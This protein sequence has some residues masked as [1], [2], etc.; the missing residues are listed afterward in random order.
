[1]PTNS[2][3]SSQLPDW[4]KHIADTSNI[5]AYVLSV[6]VILGNSV[7]VAAILKYKNLQTKTNALVCSL[8]FSDITV[9]LNTIISR[10]CACH[11]NAVHMLVISIFLY[12]SYHTSVSH[13]FIIALERYVAI[14]YPFAYIKYVSKRLIATSIIIVWIIPLILWSICWSVQE[15]IGPKGWVKK[16]GPW[17]YLIQGVIFV[18]MYI[19]ILVVSYQQAS[20]IRHLSRQNTNKNKFKSE[21]KATKTLAV[22]VFAYLVFWAPICLDEII[23][24]STSTPEMMTFNNTARIAALIL[25]GTLNSGV[26]CIVYA[27]FNKDFR[28]AYLRLF[29]CDGK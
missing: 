1:M 22:I 16:T 15:L 28:Q 20:K 25:W 12:S 19:R 23:L 5:I 8:C 17:M 10:V 9:G 14:I 26:N 7:T 24:S 6:F 18:I 4:Y 29:K 11:T 2:S 3:N 13:L 27:W 21:L